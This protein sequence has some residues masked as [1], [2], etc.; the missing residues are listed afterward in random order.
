MPA[1]RVEVRRTLKGDA[2]QYWEQLAAFDISWH[3]NVQHCQVVTSDQGAIDRI[4]Q[5]E[6][7]QQ[8]QERLT[9]LSQTEGTL[10]YHMITG[11][12]SAQKYEAQINLAQIGDQTEITWAA[13]VIANA[14]NIEAI[15]IGT[16]DIFIIAINKL[17]EILHSKLQRK[18]EAKIGSF[19][20][21]GSPKL[22]GLVAMPTAPQ[23]PLIIFLHGIGGNAENWR[24]QLEEFG[25]EHPSITLN[26]RGYG[27]SERGPSQ[28]QLADYFQ[29]II[30][31]AE[32]WGH[33]T[34]ILVGLSYGAWIATAFAQAHPGKLRALILAGGC[35]GMSEAD[36]TEREAFMN[37]RLDPL[38][39]GLAPKDF[40]QNVVDVIAGPNATNAQRSELFNSM[41][42]IPSETYRDA[43]YCFCN[44]PG[45]HDF[46]QITAPTFLITGEHDRLAPPSEIKTVAQRMRNNRSQNAGPVCFEIVHDAGHLCNLEAPKAFNQYL[47]NALNLISQQHP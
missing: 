15:R 2:T 5:D 40:A 22:T 31:A 7:G 38:N 30:R 21:D 19:T 47:R 14:Q 33:E 36:P 27:G 41:A 44:P 35:T 32:F 9:Y 39:N 18:N 10:C 13:Q 6:N 43:L 42:A 45:K 29:D 11:I 8:Y 34:F 37:A 23:K 25:E 1:K 4:F 24:P 28:T 46:S 17:N 26:L 12:A 3:P 20:I 16:K